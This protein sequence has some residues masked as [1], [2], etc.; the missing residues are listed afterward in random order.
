MVQRVG[1]APFITSGPFQE[2]IQDLERQKRMAEL[3]TQKGMETPQGQIVGGR[4]VKP[5][6]SQYANQMLSAYLGGAE[7]RDVARQQQEL[8]NKLRDVG[9]KDISE[10]L[11]IMKG[12]PA[13]T[14]YGA[15]QEG[16]TMT[17]VPAV[18][19]NR[20]AA[21]ARLLKSQSPMAAP[22][23]TKLIEQQ[24]KEPKWEK[25]EL[26]DPRT[27]NTRQGWVDVNSPNPE[28]TF[29]QGGEKPAISP[30]DAARLRYEGIPFV[31]GTAG[32]S[33]SNMSVGGGQNVVPT[34]VV[35]N[36]AGVS[37]ADA[38]F[39]P[40]DIPQYEYDPTIS[41]KANAEAAAAF[42]KQNQ[43][44]IKNA[45]DSFGLIKA[46]TDILNSGAP[47]SGRLQNIKTGIEEI[48]GKSSEASQADS[49]LE[50]IGAGLTSKVPRFEGPQS[51]KDTALYKAAAGDVANPNKPIQSRMAAL[52]T[53]IAINKKYYPQGDWDTIN[54]S[55]PVVKKQT[56]FSGQQN[57]NPQEF[58][59][60]LNP[61][62]QEAFDW[63][64]SNPTDPRA[65]EIKNRLGIQ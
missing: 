39:A 51:D 26:T 58:R 37:K 18:A 55:G 33:S 1:Q 47:S 60:T 16:P 6:W 10:A 8:A 27:G 48:F 21:I 32:V 61:K 36:V 22:L 17:E 13:Q 57:V 25:A 59:K 40:K 52:Q 38:K 42:S 53:M 4:F 54:A 11:Q 64:R 31:G 65:K 30:V 20:E 5:S 15:G 50:V 23:V 29:R 7:S 49:Q 44:N 3:L 41:P 12:T 45:K 56:F 14:V 62:D 35:S 28:A 46:A 34:N 63:A 43:A 9:A 2:E 19:G 24:F